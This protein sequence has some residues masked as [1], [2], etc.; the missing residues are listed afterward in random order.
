M[1]NEDPIVVLTRKL[2]TLI[3]KTVSIES[4]DTKLTDLVQKFDSIAQTLDETHKLVNSRMSDLVAAL[5]KAAALAQKL[6]GEEGEARGA[7][8][9]RDRAER[10][11]DGRSGH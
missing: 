5:E 3:A 9:E 10:G 4:L 1:E 11:G 6:A 8:Q 2:E 7:Q